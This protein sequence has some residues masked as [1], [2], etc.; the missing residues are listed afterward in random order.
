[1]GVAYGYPHL[2]NNMDPLSGMYSVPSISPEPQQAPNYIQNDHMLIQ[3][4]SHQVSSLKEMME[5][6]NQSLLTLMVMM[7]DK[8]SKDYS[9]APRDS[10]PIRTQ[11]NPFA[12]A[13]PVNQ[14]VYHPAKQGPGPAS[15]GPQPGTGLGFAQDESTFS[16]LMDQMRH[17]V[18]LHAQTK[19]G[20]GEPS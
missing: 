19:K 6:V 5:I 10:G 7:Q 11:G 15:H 12:E 8:S 17:L 18:N 1:M 14:G 9:A 2:A 16:T 3:S 4:L 20:V 13:M